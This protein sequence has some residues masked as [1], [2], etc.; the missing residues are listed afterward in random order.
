MHCATW[1]KVSDADHQQ[2][3]SIT[4]HH[5]CEL[6]S[7]AL[8]DNSGCNFIAPNLLVSGVHE[9]TRG[10]FWVCAV[11]LSFSLLAFQSR[12]SHGRK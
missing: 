12:A 10:Y 1:M 9:L 8:D 11:I 4:P 3:P 2:T 5:M 7:A 6:R